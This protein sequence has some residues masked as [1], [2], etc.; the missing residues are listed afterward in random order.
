[1]WLSLAA[2]IAA[3]LAIAPVL[4]HAQAPTDSVA[5]AWT[6]PGDDGSVGTATSYELR[7]WT[8]PIDNTNWDQAWSVPGTP[9]PQAA[10]TRQRVVVRGLTNGTTYYFAMK[11]QDDAGNWSGLSNLVTWSWVYDTSPPA[12]PIGLGAVRENANDVRTNW[13]PNPDADLA[14]YK[15]YRAT[16]Q[17]GPYTSLTP[18]PITSTQFLDTTI[19]QGTTTVWY[20]IS[21]FDITGN[22]SAR[23]AAVSVSMVEVAVSWRLDAGYPN[24]SRLGS[25]VHLPIMVPANAPNALVEI[26]DSGGHRVW[27]RELG[28]L[29]SG[30][31]TLDWDGKNDAG[32]DVA[33]G[34]YTAWLTA[35]NH[36][37]S[38][39]LARVP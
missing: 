1:V 33:P 35:G 3:L 18:S 25:P 14:G 26:N 39:K 2:A 22:E 5:L 17:G 16:S 9:P 15:V 19:P 20:Q 38:V 30:P 13:L 4:A 28:N 11:T 29:T 7:F 10:G 8:S 21:A 37:F 12:T 27:S 32:R 24:P 34:V 36:R 31:Y 23:S 6:A